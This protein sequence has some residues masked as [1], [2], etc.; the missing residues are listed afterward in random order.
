MAE[1]SLVGCSNTQKLCQL[2]S[3]QSRGD[4]TACGRYHVTTLPRYHVTTVPR[5][6]AVSDNANNWV[7]EYQ[8]NGNQLKI[9]D[10]T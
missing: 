4:V 8:C 3:P 6:Q 9:D 10:I 1:R 2:P 7:K 5:Y